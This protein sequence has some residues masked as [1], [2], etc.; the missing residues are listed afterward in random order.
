[1]WQ[2]PVGRGG[3]FTDIVARRTDGPLVSHKPLEKHG[4][5][6]TACYGP[7]KKSIVLSREPT[8]RCSVMREIRRRK[9][10][11]SNKADS[12]SVMIRLERTGFIDPDVFSLFGRQLGQ[13]HA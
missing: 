2:F 8:T 7:P 5:E 6:T 12:I 11:A 13:L 1:M 10:A 4:L 9:N 3:T